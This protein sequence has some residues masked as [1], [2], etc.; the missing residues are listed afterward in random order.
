VN[1]V[2]KLLRPREGKEVTHRS[3]E[4]EKERKKNE[5]KRERRNERSPSSF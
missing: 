5:R 4:K 3:R 2:H 1:E